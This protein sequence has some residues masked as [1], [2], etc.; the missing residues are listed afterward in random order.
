MY[1]HCECLWPKNKNKFE[2]LKFEIEKSY[3]KPY[4]FI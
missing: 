3:K 4:N 1:P 2:N